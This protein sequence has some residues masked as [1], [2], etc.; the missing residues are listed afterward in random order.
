VSIWT[1]CIHP[2]DTQTSMK[3]NSICGSLVLN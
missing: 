3:F 2:E 1:L